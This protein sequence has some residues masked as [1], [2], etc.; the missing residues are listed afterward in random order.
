MAFKE[1]YSRSPFRQGCGQRG[2]EGAP[3]DARCTISAGALFAL[4]AFLGW[5][6]EFP[7]PRLPVGSSVSQ[8]PTLL[9]STRSG[10]VVPSGGQEP[11]RE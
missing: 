5:I 4:T 6:G 10:A 11:V 7:E 2:E 8:R 1:A 3:D 9:S